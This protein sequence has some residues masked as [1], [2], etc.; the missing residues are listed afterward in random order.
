MTGRATA[1]RSSNGAGRVL[2]ST[3]SAPLWKIM[4][5]MAR[6]SDNFT[7]EMALKQLGALHGKGGSTAAG[8]AVVRQFLSAD[9][10]ALGGVRI[11]DGSGLSRLD[12]LTVRTVAELLVSRLALARRQEAVRRRT[13]GGRSSGHARGAPAPAAHARSGA[14]ED[15]DDARRRRRSRAT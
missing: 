9:G 5:F 15:G 7:A 12:R 14:R 10:I 6:E 13:G 3:R 11:A 2:A 4:R 1:T 8:A